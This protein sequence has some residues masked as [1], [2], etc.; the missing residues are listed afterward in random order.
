MGKE[1]KYQKKLNYQQNSQ[2]KGFQKVGPQDQMIKVDE[3]ELA[4]HW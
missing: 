1:E 3:L 2:K 4:K